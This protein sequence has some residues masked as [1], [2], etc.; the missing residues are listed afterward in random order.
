MGIHD[1]PQKRREKAHGDVVSTEAPVC[2]GSVDTE[3]HFELIVPESVFRA[4][5][6]KPTSCTLSTKSGDTRRAI[7]LFY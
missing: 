6:T 3:V 2:Q 7:L 1:L 4:T 5:I